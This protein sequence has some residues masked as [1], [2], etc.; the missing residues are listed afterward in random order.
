[1]NTL[2]FGNKNNMNLITK[3][4]T[5]S[6]VL[7]FAFIGSTTKSQASVFLACEST[8]S[9]AA[10]GPDFRL[11]TDLNAVIVGTL[12]A[13]CRDKKGDIYSVSLG[14]I[15]PGLLI[16]ESIFTLSCP[17]VSKRKLKRNGSVAFLGTRATVAAIAGVNV[18]LA[19]NHKGGFCLLAGVEL[20]I[21][22]AVNIGA[23]KIFTGT[24]NENNLESVWD[25]GAY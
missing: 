12:L 5:I 13:D 21:G 1:M 8:Y 10:E 15:S 25:M 4:A 20:G 18:G 6:F 19:V 24:V 11:P 14:G 2:N 9:S 22:A 23:M 3:I 16:G 7:I 17:T